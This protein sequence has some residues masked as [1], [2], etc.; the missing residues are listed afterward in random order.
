MK[1]YAILLTLLTLFTFLLALAINDVFLPF[2]LYIV[3]TVVAI[4]LKDKI[5]IGVK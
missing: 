4:P 2:T 3:G 5:I 1:N